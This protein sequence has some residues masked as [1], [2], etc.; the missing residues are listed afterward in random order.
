VVHHERAAR[1]L[2][3]FGILCY[4]VAKPKKDSRCQGTVFTNS[5]VGTKTGG[6]PQECMAKMFNEKSVRSN[7]AAK[8]K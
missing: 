1:A 7:D 4:D 6:R 2:E 8:N 5:L 3:R